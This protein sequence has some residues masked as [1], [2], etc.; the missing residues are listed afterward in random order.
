MDNGYVYATESTKQ[1]IAIY[2]CQTA[3]HQ[4]TPNTEQRTENGS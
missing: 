2:M 4:A 1:T 3:T